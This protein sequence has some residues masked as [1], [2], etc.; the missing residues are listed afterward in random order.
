[1]AR[2]R[3]RSSS[4]QDRSDYKSAMEEPDYHQPDTMLDSAQ[5]QSVVKNQMQQQQQN[6]ML[7][8]NNS[9]NNYRRGSGNKVVYG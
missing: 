7:G 3:A 2:D 6:V 9:N 4:N 5:D 8:T 1:M